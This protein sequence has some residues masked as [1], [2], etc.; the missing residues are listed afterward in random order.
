MQLPQAASNE[1]LSLR[2]WAWFEWLHIPPGSLHNTGYTV[3]LPFISP[4]ARFD[5]V[6]LK[7]MTNSLWCMLGDGSCR[8]VNKLLALHPDGGRALQQ[9]LSN[10]L[11]I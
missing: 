11:P 2:T 7:S 4:P 6:E 5:Q 8:Y 3:V 1:D 9:S 10:F